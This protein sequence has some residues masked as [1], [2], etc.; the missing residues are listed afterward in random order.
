MIKSNLSSLTSSTISQNPLSLKKRGSPISTGSS[1]LG[2]SSSTPHFLS[3]EQ[4]IS[5]NSRGTCNRK[6]SDFLIKKM[7]A[8]SPTS[9]IYLAN[10]R[11]TNYT[12]VIKEIS[13]EVARFDDLK[14]SIANEI[15]VHSSLSHPNI[16]EFL[17][18]FHDRENIFL[19]LEYASDNNLY[20][21]RRRG[22]DIA[23]AVGRQL[24]TTIKY[25]WDNN[26]M[27]RDIKHE[28]ILVKEVSLDFNYIGS[29][30]QIM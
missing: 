26:V 15:Q 30:H 2:F 9:R 10:D 28:N 11:I 12:V 7:I 19:I 8:S 18:F 24:L 13:K 14:K 21:D 23:K 27:H 17:G 3:N 16:V 5:Q 6:G 1:L 25:L 4:D 29:H 20:Q 22:E